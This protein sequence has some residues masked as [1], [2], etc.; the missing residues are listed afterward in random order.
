MQHIIFLQISEYN[1]KRDDYFNNK[2]NI[3][4]PSQYCMSLSGSDDEV[5]YVIVSI[6]IHVVQ[7]MDSGQYYCYFCITTQERV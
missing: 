2:T 6:K 1:S 7:Y 3:A 5:V 4:L